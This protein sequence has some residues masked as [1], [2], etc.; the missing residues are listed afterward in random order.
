[1]SFARFE[2]QTQVGLHWRRGLQLHP[3]GEA[4]SRFVNGV[5]KG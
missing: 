4:A 1:M 3:P 2:V 5:Y